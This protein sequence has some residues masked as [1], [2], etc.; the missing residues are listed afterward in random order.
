MRTAP[1]GVADRGSGLY[2]PFS[3]DGQLTTS[4]GGLFQLRTLWPFQDSELKSASLSL[5]CASSSVL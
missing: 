4:G 5:T 2:L 3:Y 1:H